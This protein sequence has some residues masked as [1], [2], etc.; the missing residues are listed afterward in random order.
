L[1][2]RWNPNSLYGCAKEEERVFLSRQKEPVVILGLADPITFR[3][4]VR[5]QVKKW[6]D[7]PPNYPEWAGSYRSITINRLAVLKDEKGDVQLGFYTPA[8]RQW[9]V[10]QRLRSYNR[11]ELGAYR[12][13]GELYEGMVKLASP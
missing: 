10:T 3:C 11:R 2:D 4:F 8:D 6:P 5:E 12:K 7:W 1:V 13:L 9:Y